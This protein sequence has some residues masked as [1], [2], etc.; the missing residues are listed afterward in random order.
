MNSS[1]SAVSTW[2]ASLGWEPNP[3][4]REAWRAYANG[5]DG[6]VQAP[7]GMGKTFA[8]LG[9]VVDEACREG[10]TAK[11]LQVIWIAPIR[12][13][14]KEIEA[15]AR[16]MLE[17]VGL[18]WQVGIRTGDTPA[19][20]RARQRRRL[21]Q[22]LIT[23]PESLHLLFCAADHAVQFASC[24]LLVV[25][26]WHALLGS[27]RGVQVELAAAHL[28]HIA[29]E[30]RTWGLTATIGN[31]D[32]ALGVLCPAGGVLVQSQAEKRTE[33]VSLMPRQFERLAWAGFLG[34]PLLDQVLEVVKAHRT[35][36][37]FTNTRSQAEIWYHRLLDADPDL[38]GQIALHHGSMA[39]DARIWI[40][41]AIGNGLLKAVVCTS[42]LDLGVDFPP[43]EAVV[44]IGSPKG[45]AR[46]LQ[47]AGRSGH[48]PGGISRIHF[49]PTHGLELIE[50]AALRTAV[51]QGWVESRTPVV[52]AFDVLTQWLC[53]RAL[54]G[55]FEPDEAKGEVLGTH[56]F[57][58]VDEVEWQSCL[59]FVRFGGSALE[60]YEEYRRV[61]VVGGRWVM[62]D[63]R[64]ARRHRM[65]I[66][67]IVSDPMVA[68]KLNRVGVVGHVEAT[69]IER[70]TAGDVF[71]FAGR[72]LELVRHN[73]AVAEVKPAKRSTQRV[74]VWSGGRLPLSTELGSALRE[75]LDSVARGSA[76]H[77]ELLRLEP[78]LSLQRARSHVPLKTELLVEEFTSDDGHHVCVF[79]FE[80]RAV[81]EGLAMLVSHRLGQTRS[82]TITFA[83]NDYGF[84]LLSNEPLHVNEQQLRELLTSKGLESDVLGSLNAS[85]L[86]RRRFKEVS[87]ISGLQF[88]PPQGTSAKH[89]RTHSGL[90]F[91]VFADHDRQHVLYQQ[92]LEE[93][94]ADQ[95]QLASLLRALERM[96][97][98]EWRWCRPGQVT[99]LAFPL[100]V[101]RMRET[102]SSEELEMRI[103]R[104]VIAR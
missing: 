42:S 85:D 29:P 83:C 20:E 90:L 67:T 47:R 7:T 43:V 8:A 82:Q 66:G 96:K 45:V 54:G 11:G 89:L 12:A 37:V 84:E 55:G 48:Q 104:M 93:V 79:P 52:R 76:K 10:A 21:P 50:G 87:V 59:A 5:G 9:G 13:L 3:F 81:H 64:M 99:P 15:S 88:Q 44:Q 1:V 61:E 41:E 75:E 100:M 26:E 57:R 86:A 58:S 22:V 25:D 23:T 30:L 62:P 16:R 74:P 4:Q 32:E 78:L 39:K 14:S 38:A 77:L 72:Q 102:M 68:V 60:A 33:I 69:F 92:A 36:L 18:D 98:A 71:W 19:P 34:I 27:K 35:T 53:T 2:F 63:R 103:E 97:S 80:G 51:Q 6:L 49:V 24:R 31:L 101:D 65:A 70:M 94:L 91:D 46:F 56:A 95:L 28:R 73:G 17:G 40:E